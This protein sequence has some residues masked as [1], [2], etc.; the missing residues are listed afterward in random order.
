MANQR[1]NDKKDV[2]T[3]LSSQRREKA[4]RLAIALKISKT[5]L[6]GLLIDSANEFALRTQLS[7]MHKP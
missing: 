5:E 2:H 1:S 3:F 6:I 7:R 4:E